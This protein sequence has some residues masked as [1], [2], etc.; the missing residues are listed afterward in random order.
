MQN[1]SLLSSVWFQNCS[2]FSCTSW[3]WGLELP[4]LII[5]NRRRVFLTAH[6]PGLIKARVYERGWEGGGGLEEGGR[7]RCASGGGERQKQSGACKQVHPPW[8]ITPTPAAL[9]CF[10]CA[11]SEHGV[12]QQGK[13]SPSPC[14]PSLNR[15]LICADSQAA[16]ARWPPVN[17][18]GSCSAFCKLRGPRARSGSQEAPLGP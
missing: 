12:R 18:E 7:K 11:V 17:K 14:V 1:F 5:N 13:H 3:H 15:L 10:P 16:P 2:S 9:C 8:L 6:L 4:L